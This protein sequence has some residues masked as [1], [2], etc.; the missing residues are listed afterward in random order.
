MYMKK[1]IPFLILGLFASHSASA[2]SD[3][4]IS[5]P[6]YPATT[7]LQEVGVFKGYE[8]GSLGRDK[9][10]NRAEVLKTI[11]VASKTDLSEASS[12]DFNDVPKDAWFAPY[13]NQAAAT[14]IVSG[15][16]GTG[17]FAP[18]R[19]VNKAEFLKMLTL[20]F[21][22]TPTSYELNATANDVPNDAWFAPYIR[23]ALEFNIMQ[24][25][26]QN[27]AYPSKE[28]TRGEVAELIFEMLH[29]GRGLEIQTLL[30]LTDRHLNKSLE[31]VENK[32]L[33]TAAI[34]VAIAE[35]FSD[36]GLLIM[37][38]HNVVKSA[39]KVV[40]A[41]KSIISA[42]SAGAKGDLDQV[43]VEA[44]AAW[45]QADESVQLND[46]EKMQNISQQLKTIASQLANDARANGGTD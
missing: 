44:K 27:N 30:N 5:D 26:A 40:D 22:L 8:D 28:L 31:L 37:P 43:I 16:A 2:F 42:L 9:L 34:L 32:D 1:L 7:Y 45:G 38:E 14:G 17:N 12:A 21:N 25:D 33:G 18:G 11:F 13:V 29:R 10:I 35:R 19:T 4:T 20:A 41:H 15:D 36:Y 3:I 24:P 6:Y 23:F 39:N 46:N